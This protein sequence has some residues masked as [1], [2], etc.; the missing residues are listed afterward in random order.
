M[1]PQANRTAALNGISTLKTVYIQ[2]FLKSPRL[3]EEQR[4]AIRT[5][6]VIPV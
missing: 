5:A 3:I 6:E 1:L 4:P 2:Y